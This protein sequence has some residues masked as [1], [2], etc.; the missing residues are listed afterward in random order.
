MPES[1]FYLC[2]APTKNTP[3]YLHAWQAYLCEHLEKT[4]SDVETMQEKHGHITIIVKIGEEATW[5]QAKEQQTE[6]NQKA[7]AMY[8][9]AM[10]K[11]ELKKKRKKK[12]KKLNSNGVDEMSG[13]SE[14]ECDLFPNG[15]AYK[16]LDVYELPK[17]LELKET[18]TP[19]TVQNLADEDI[20][21]LKN[22][23]SQSVY[24]KM[25]SDAGRWS[26]STVYA[27]VLLHYLCPDP[28]LKKG[29]EFR[30]RSIALLKRQTKESEK[31][32]VLKFL[33]FSVLSIMLCI[34]TIF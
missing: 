16:V 27:P 8:V 2:L 29:W 12:E 30:S 23:L 26:V 18:S 5:P 3:K 17:P 14:S 34:Y 20:R 22:A 11:E 7:H 21:R 24:D 31:T 10:A 32:K 28:E 6:F 19:R 9:S 25:F 4:L 15:R 33:D 1:P 13:S